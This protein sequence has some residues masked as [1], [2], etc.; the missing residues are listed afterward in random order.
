MIAQVMC[1]FLGLPAKGVFY[2]CSIL[3]LPHIS[4]LHYKNYTST[5]QNRHA[6]PKDVT[7]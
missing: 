4:G 7:I 3:L 5:E 1:L 2:Y 6:S